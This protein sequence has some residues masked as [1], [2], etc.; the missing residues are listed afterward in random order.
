M[1]YMFYVN[2]QWMRTVL[3][4]KTQPIINLI[5]WCLMFWI[6]L[7][8]RTTVGNQGE[9]VLE[10]LR[11][12][13]GRKK[14]EWP[15][16]GS[17]KGNCTSL[18]HHQ[19]AVH[20]WSLLRHCL[21]D[22]RSETFEFNTC[23]VAKYATKSHCFIYCVLSTD[24]FWDMDGYWQDRWHARNRIGLGRKVIHLVKR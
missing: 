14:Q 12:L 24:A 7:K 22:C 2:H 4:P 18:L 17:V 15:R 8:G 19:R 13:K 11:L 16:K 20:S 1:S 3:L 10:L 5:S 9:S 23:K 21:T 6:V